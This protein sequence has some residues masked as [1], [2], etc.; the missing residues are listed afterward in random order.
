MVLVQHG[1]RICQT[2]WHFEGFQ[3]LRVCKVVAICV[4]GISG[5]YNGSGLMCSSA[6]RQDGVTGQTE[7][8]FEEFGWFACYVCGYGL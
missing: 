5:K 2:E 1:G 7:W 8:H 4:M 3:Q 6:G